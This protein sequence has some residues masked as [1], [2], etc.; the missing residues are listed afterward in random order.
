MDGKA[1]RRPGVIPLG[2]V[3]DE[4]VL[5]PPP[6]PVFSG[7]GWMV[8]AAITLALAVSEQVTSQVLITRRCIRPLRNT[9]INN[10]EDYAIALARCAPGFLPVVA[11]RVH[12]DINLLATVALAGVG[13]W[14]RGRRIAYDHTF[15]AP[16]RN[17]TKRIRDAGIGLIASGFVA[18]L[19]TSARDLGMVQS[20]S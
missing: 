6:R 20:L 11:L 14:L 17:D 9:N 18:W 13:G 10:L 4:D 1:G 5:P 16:Q 15:G 7:V 19:A 3:P 2:D 8:G 12:S